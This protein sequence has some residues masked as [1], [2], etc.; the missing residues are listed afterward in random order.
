MATPQLPMSVLPMFKPEMVESFFAP[1]VTFLS[2]LESAKAG[3]VASLTTI[4]PPIGTFVEM[5]TAPLP[6]PD[7]LTEAKGAVIEALGV[8]PPAAPVAPAVASPEPAVAPPA[9]GVKRVITEV[10]K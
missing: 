2:T 10:I 3:M 4:A 6:K 1:A 9:P 8:A 5:L 7:V